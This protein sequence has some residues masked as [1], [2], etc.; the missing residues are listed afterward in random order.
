[1]FTCQLIYHQTKT[2]L[3]QPAGANGHH[4]AKFL[5]ITVYDFD[6]RYCGSLLLLSVTW[7][8]STPK[9]EPHYFYSFVS[10]LRFV[11]FGVPDLFLCLIWVM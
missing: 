10:R 8:V 6:W 5:R 2:L 9:A 11:V 1:M 7:E 3:S 4:L